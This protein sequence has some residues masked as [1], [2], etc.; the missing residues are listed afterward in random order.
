MW[1]V[2]FDLLRLLPTEVVFFWLMLI[3][4]RIFGS[5]LLCIIIS[6]SYK[7]QTDNYIFFFLCLNQIVSLLSEGALYK[8]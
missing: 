8:N 2:C 3:L 5:L 7:I 1:V 4:I 6:I